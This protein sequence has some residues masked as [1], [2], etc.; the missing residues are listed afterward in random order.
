M[1][2]LRLLELFLELQERVG[3]IDEDSTCFGLRIEAE[4]KAIRNELLKW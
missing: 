4:I 3:N 2:K 1:D